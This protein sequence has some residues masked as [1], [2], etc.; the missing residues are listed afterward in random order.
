MNEESMKNY[1]DLDS[2]RFK[3]SIFCAVTLA[4]NYAGSA[5]QP[6]RQVIDDVAVEI[7]H[8]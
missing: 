4:W 5:H 7:R 8:H 2:N 6:S 3:H 1:L